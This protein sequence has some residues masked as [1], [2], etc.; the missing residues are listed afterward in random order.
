MSTPAPQGPDTRGEQKATVGEVVARISDQF[1]RILRGEIQLI[2]LQLMEKMKNVGI[3]AALFAAAGLFAFFAFGV[4]IAA[5]VLGIATA[6][7]A[8]LSAII[9]GVALLVIA[10]ILALVGKGRLQAGEAPSAEGAKEN[11]K[12]DLNA[13]KEGFRS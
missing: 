6:L 2:Q 11:L 9:V 8:W 13:V 12:A 3:G 4:L 10:G 7:P 5:A 1:S